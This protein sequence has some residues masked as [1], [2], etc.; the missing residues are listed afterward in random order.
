MLRAVRLSRAR[1]LRAVR[2]SRARLLSCSALPQPPSDC[3]RFE[4]CVRAF[5]RIRSGVVRT[6]CDKSFFLSS[7]TGSDLYLKCDQQQFTGSFKER[8][9]RNAL[10]TLS[11]EEARSGVVAAS[12]GN[13]ALAL[14]WHGQQLGVPVTVVM[15]T[16]APM[17]KVDKC[18]LFGAN[19]IVHGSHIGEAK[20][21]AIESFAQN[22]LRY[23]NGYGQSTH[24]LGQPISSP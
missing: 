19:V 18:R 3:V 2:L 8:G 6:A 20:Q 7:V 15:P 24:G 1:L 12:A 23:I 13:H 22:G 16:I 14:C 11:P 17:A 10:L 5:H 9:A 4:H 21:Y